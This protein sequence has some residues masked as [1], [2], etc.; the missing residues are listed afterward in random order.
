MT[1]NFQSDGVSST[2][3]RLV[4]MHNNNGT[5]KIIGFDHVTLEKHIT[6]AVRHPFPEKQSTRIYDLQGRRVSGNAKSGIFVG[7][8]QKHIRASGFAE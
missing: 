8:G 2:T 5:E 1:V 6:D 3:I 7:K 4:A